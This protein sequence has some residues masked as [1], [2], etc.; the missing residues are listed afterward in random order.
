MYPSWGNY[1]GHQPQN[2]SGP[3]PRKQQI[4]GAT[5]PTGGFGGFDAP[6]GGSLFSSLQEQHRQQMQQ[7]QMLHQKQ[8][9]SVLHHNNTAREFSG[10]AA[11]GPFPGSSWKPEGPGSTDAGFGAPSYFKQGDAQPLR[12]PQAPQSDQPPPPPPQPKDAQPKPPPPE[13]ASAKTSPGDGTPKSKEDQQQYWYHQHLQNLQKL[14][15]EKAKQNQGD[16]PMLLP[17]PIQQ[18][19]PPPTES[20]KSAP[21]PPP[22]KE[23]PPV[24]PPPPEEPEVPK[25]PEEA[26]RLQQL[27][28]A[29]AQWQQV[30]QQRAGM[31][32][33]ALMQQHE[34]LQHILE[35]Y[36]QLIQQPANIQSM[37][38]EMQLRHYELQQQQ[39]TPLF[40]DWE[41]TFKLWYE[42]FQT[43]PHKDQLQDYELQWKQW[44]EQMNA[45][46]A[47][48][49]ER[50]TTLQ[51]MVP[52]PSSQY[53]SGVVGQYG[54]YSG[55]DVQ[56]QQQI[57]SPGV[58]HSPGAV[59]PRAQ[60][61]RPPGFGPHSESPGGPPVRGSSPAG[62]GIR[63][64]GP[65][66]GPPPQ[67]QGPM[68]PRLD[69]PRGN[70]PRFDGPPRFDQPQQRFDGPPRFDPP[71]Q[72]FD[73]PPRFEPPQQRFDAPP[74]FDHPQQRFDSPSRF[75]KPQQRFDGPPRF[76]P[77]HHRFDGPPRFDQPQHRFDGP[78]RFDQPQHRFD[79]P[80]RFDQPPRGNQ[81]RFGQQPRLEQPHRQI[82]PP[83]PLECPAGAQ[84]R[85][86]PSPQPKTEL[87]TT[88]QPSHNDSKTPV[89]LT[90]QPPSTKENESKLDKIEEDL[91]DDNLDSADGFFVQ[92]DPIP[93]TSQTGE[94]TAIPDVSNDSTSKDKINEVSIKP[95][96]TVPKPLPPKSTA[97]AQ[98]ISKPGGQ[99]ANDKNTPQQG[100]KSSGIKQESQLPG[101]AQSRL[102]PSEPLPA[103]A[104]GRGRGQPP[105]PIQGRGRGQR[106]R[107]DFRGLSTLPPAE[108]IH[109][110]PYDY[111]PPQDDMETNEEQE[112]YQWQDTSYEELN[113][114]ETEVHPEQ[115]IWLP[116]EHHFPTDEEEYYEE[117]MMEGMPRGRGGPPLGRGGPPRGRGGPP[118]GRGGP[119]MGRGGPPMGRGGPPMGRGG[120]PMGRGGPPMGWGGPPM[121][122][123]GP[124]MGR[125]GPPMGRGGPP[126]GRGGPPM[127]RGEPM[128]R[129]WEDPETAEYWDEEEPYWEE[130]RPPMRGMRPPF[131][132]GRGRPPRGH[133]GFMHPGRG[134]P[135]HP[136]HG[137]VD[138]D[139]VGP[140]VDPDNTEMDSMKPPVHR[141][142]EPH[143][144]PMHPDMIRGRWRPPPPHDMVDP[145]GEPLYDE[146]MERESGWNRPPHSRGPPPPPH[147]IL[148]R[149]GMR[150]R[151]MGRV[152][153]RGMRHPGPPHE[154]FEEAYSEGFVEDYGHGD[155]GYGWRPQRDYP[156][157]EYKRE[158]HCFDLEW[159]RERALP[160]R[161]YPPRIPPPER[162]REEL[163]SEDRERGRP[164]LN[165]DDGRG[166]L[167]IHEYKD[168]PPYRREGPPYQPV[169]TG[170]DRPTR[171]PP[172]NQR[173]YP[174]DYEERRSYHEDHRTEP[175][176]D[177]PPPPTLAAPAAKAPETPVDPAAQGASGGSVLALSQRQHEI[178]L[179]AAQELKLIRELQE[180]K[181]PA[182]EPQPTVPEVKSDLAV[183]LLG[184]EIPPE[185][186]SALKGMATSGQPATSDP[187]AWDTKPA[188]A[189]YQTPSSTAPTPQ[190]MPKTV[191]Y[192]HGHEPGATVERISYGERIVLRPDP[193]PS[194]RAYQKE[195]LGVRDPYYERRWPD[196]DRRE[197]NR[198][199]EMYRDKPP[200][201]YERE[202]F[203]RERYSSR[204]DRPPQGPPPRPGYRE[205]ERE[206]SLNRDRDEHYGRPGYDRPS[207]E[208]VGL[209]R[210]GP[211]R[212]GHGSSP[213]T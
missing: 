81:P 141:D 168:E 83:T 159:D 128:D 8:L 22:P 176:M 90:E 86:E 82:G 84:L 130:R 182:P 178:I 95:S 55:Q 67:Y 198:D 189:S 5:P 129:H 132:L 138:H 149:G 98:N 203:E 135:P 200:L 151:P 171:P 74:R 50:V 93:Q 121:G 163:W 12:G 104:H 207:Y 72:R 105:I 14:K 89:K 91:A 70:K 34:K 197:Y 157:D 150:R 24:P 19:P 27:Q 174:S 175:P 2:F 100:L 136:P 32:Y 75:D 46:Q 199:R 183:G 4:G 144:H 111:M 148:E 51:A 107:E 49:Q 146:G 73:G 112:Q 69:G 126:M 29:A 164:Y 33:Q 42:Q 188:S 76:D 80:P 64:L 158:D 31:Q 165:E 20:P 6:A 118:M 192:G 190:V 172:P 37:S 205:R 212:Y 10:G 145:M 156:H 57:A 63:P 123:G 201:D 28:A 103:V 30:Q 68:G 193:I 154:E 169:P 125:G 1:G 186:R 26:A 18:T 23:E 133:P 11:G 61:P 101:K 173:G 131:P 184:L 16:G 85:V 99:M 113:D 43:Y 53:G 48:L 206:G 59:G 122:R 194:E 143:G 62:R 77:P 110:M 115:D 202:R 209:D 166:E 56:M 179:K 127:G 40:Q 170:W 79:G 180:S 3:G 36:Q 58:Q 35:K 161:D 185:V 124:P 213:Y 25:D 153:G 106:G 94:K 137:A 108:E 208:R 7:L 210:G 38:T 139:P 54:Q 114:E 9:Q 65:P 21:P 117:P 96:G 109:E 97:T 119:P 87:V 187:G 41:H 120:P 155:Y 39:F 177:I 134:R 211:E 181:P 92:S 78:P 15:H 88:P 195:P 52:Y 196:M 167:R 17:P 162:I 44:Q 60:G 160:E 102:E 147:E 142:L 140:P 191:D 66:P 13:S 116:E 204:E 47:H 152:M 71:Q 45:T